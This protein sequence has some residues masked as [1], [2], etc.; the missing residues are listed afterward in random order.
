M[1][2]QFDGYPSGHGAELSDFLDGRSSVNGFNSSTPPNAYNG[3]GCLAAQMIAYFKTSVGGV[4]IHA[5]V[6]GRDYWQE[7]EYHV[8]EDKIIVKN[9]DEVIFNGTWDNF[10]SFCSDEEFV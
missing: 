4:Y 9:P 1:Y 6:Q 8:Y 3:M 5:P 7:F 2:R 10:H